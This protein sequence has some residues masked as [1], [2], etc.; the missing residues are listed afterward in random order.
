MAVS[1]KHMQ[2]MQ[3][4]VNSSVQSKRM[5]FRLLQLLRAHG[6]RIYAMLQPCL[7]HKLIWCTKQNMLTDMRNPPKAFWFDVAAFTDQ[8]APGM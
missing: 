1:V 6:L 2:G 8:R 5:L 4:T 7:G 3:K